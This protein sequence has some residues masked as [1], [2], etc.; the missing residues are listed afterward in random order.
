MANKNLT[1]GNVV[2]FI[3]R[4]LGGK[5]NTAL[6]F[7]TPSEAEAVLVEGELLDAV[8]AA[9][10]PSPETNAPQSV[11]AV[12]VNPAEQASLTL[13]DASSNPV[14]TLKSTD[15]GLRNN[16]IK[17][18]V[19][20]GSTAGKKLTTQFGNDYYT[21][22]NVARNAFGVQY[23]GAAATATMSITGTSIVLQ[24]PSGTT[25]DTIELATFKTVQQVVDRINSLTGFAASVKDGNNNKL[26]LNGLDYVTSQDV[27]T[28]EFVVTANLQ[29]IIDWF[30][31]SGEGFVTATRGATAGAV[32]GN[33]GFTY[34]SGG[35]DGIVTNAEWAD[36]YETLQTVDVQWVT[37]ISPEPS[38]WAMNDA[39]VSFMS[40]NKKERRAIV[41]TDLGTSNEDAISAAKSLNSDRTSLVH[42]GHYSY[43]PQ[44]NLVLRPAYLTA[45][46]IA[47]AFAGVN[48]GTPM[49]NKALKVVALERDLRN[50]TETDVLINGGVLCVENTD[51]GYKVVQ[52]IST[53]LI[54]SNYNRREVSTGVAVD[55]T[56]RNWRQ[57]VDSLRG[58]KSNPLLI[59]QA[60][61][62]SDSVLR[63]LSRPEPQGVGVLAGDEAN[64][65][66]KN[67]QASIEGDVLRLQAQVSPVIP[68]NYILI[69][70]AAVPWSG[71]AS[72]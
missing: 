50:P 15:Y 54:N 19:E 65:P 35:S 42:I 17:V 55:F 44:G 43:D 1:V 3:G 24:A 53:W 60:I 28:A 26:A 48:P 47:G 18:K 59:S 39:H 32:P 34:L 30:N 33:V 61:S 45:A 62:R 5:P 8:R 27:K 36:A 70:I 6:R 31:S 58:S 46:L 49:T 4:S 29:A 12:R 52:S 71:S 51:T 25:I 63:E 68:N 9:F 38:I 21:A 41:G 56:A 13:L 2:A 20:T 10:D 16:Q 67:I 7:G 11:V 72:A 14:I 69:T 40:N 64:P 23:S 22:D 37:P 57:A 66:Y